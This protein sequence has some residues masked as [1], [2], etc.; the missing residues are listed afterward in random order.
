MNPADRVAG[1]YREEMTTR[2]EAFSVVAFAIF[3]AGYGPDNFTP[4][5]DAF[6]G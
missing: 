6:R 3:S 2:G 4:F 1:I 5:A